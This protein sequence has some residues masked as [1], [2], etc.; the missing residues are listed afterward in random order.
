MTWRCLSGAAAGAS[1]GAHNAQVRSTPAQVVGQ[2]LLDLRLGRIFVRRDE[3]RCLHD[4]AVDAV[5]ALHGLFI[6]ECSLQR[7]RF[8][9]RAKS[10]ESHNAVA[11]R[12]D[13]GKNAGADGA[14]VEMYGAGAAL[15]EAAAEARA[16]QTEIVTQRVQQRHRWIVDGQLHGCAVDVERDGLSHDGRSITTSRLSSMNIASHRHAC[17][18]ANACGCACM[19]GLVPDARATARQTWLTCSSALRTSREATHADR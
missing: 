14:A 15:A 1:H 10:L 13:G 18:A 8:F 4:H 6:D 2:C 16:V 17:L 9:R 12:A 11:D 7:M 19:S 5:A 3:R